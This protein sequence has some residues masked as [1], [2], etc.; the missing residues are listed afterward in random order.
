VRALTASHTAVGNGVCLFSKAAPNPIDLGR[1]PD[2]AQV[3]WKLTYERV[4]SELRISLAGPLAEAK[5]VN[6]PLRTIGARSDLQH[7]LQLQSRLLVLADYIESISK[8]SPTVPENLLTLERR[9][10]RRWVG[11]PHIWKLILSVADRLSRDEMVDWQ[12]LDQII[13][14]ASLPRL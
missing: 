7:C 4:T 9:R 1:H 11:N 3:A 8:F 5:A 12:K 10:V 13:N 2:N 14:E 6:K